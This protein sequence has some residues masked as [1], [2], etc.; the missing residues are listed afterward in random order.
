MR[1]IF[2]L[3]KKVAFKYVFSF[4]MGKIF[5]II[6]NSSNNKLSSSFGAIELVF[7]NAFKVV[8]AH[9]KKRALF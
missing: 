5:W 3:R 8:H 4:R 6:K 1:Q 2:P 7:K 9:R